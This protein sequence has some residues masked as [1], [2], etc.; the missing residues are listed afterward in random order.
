MNDNE[1]KMFDQMLTEWIDEMQ[2]EMLL[3]AFDIE[4]SD[5]PRLLQKGVCSG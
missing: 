2:W 3:K 4:V 1:R 5:D